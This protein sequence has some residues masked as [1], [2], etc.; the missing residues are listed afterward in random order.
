MSFNWKKKS[1]LFH[2]VH[3]CISFFFCIFSNNHVHSV[4]LDLVLLDVCS[5]EQDM[6]TDLCC[7]HLLKL[8]SFSTINSWFLYVLCRLRPFPAILLELP[9]SDGLSPCLSVCLSVTQGLTA[10]CPP[11]PSCLGFETTPLTFSILVTMMLGFKLLKIKRVSPALCL[12]AL[13]VHTGS[14]WLL[15]T[16]LLVLGL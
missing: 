15:L 2:V 16:A 3:E 7:V 13:S 8:P 12:T 11:P 6:N 9:S 14:L 4:Y 5:F 1:I 10:Y